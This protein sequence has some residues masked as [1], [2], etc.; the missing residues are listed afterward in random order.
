[1]CDELY[2]Q[3][4]MQSLII[5]VLRK[6][7][8]CSQQQNIKN[9]RK[10]YTNETRTIQQLQQLQQLQFGFRFP[11]NKCMLGFQQLKEE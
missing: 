3:I 10:L 7:I 5:D 11:S 9:T 8:G 4:K 6:V 2:Q 1:M